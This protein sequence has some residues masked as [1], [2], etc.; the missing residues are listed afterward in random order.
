MILTIT[1]ALTDQTWTIS[2]GLF[3]FDFV[4][5]F[6]GE[7]VLSD[8][9][10]IDIIIETQTTWTSFMLSERFNINGPNII[11][12]ELDRVSA[13]MVLNAVRA[14][15]LAGEYPNG[16]TVCS[17]PDV[18]NEGEEVEYVVAIAINR[19]RL[20]EEIRKLSTSR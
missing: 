12:H 10:C 18:E 11:N 7:Q 19:E 16:A 3:H 17:I 14:L 6:V 9:E 1:N 15:M 2:G 4:T 13:F 5:S 8:D 20:H